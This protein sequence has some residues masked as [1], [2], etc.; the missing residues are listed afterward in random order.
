[1]ALPACGPPTGSPPTGPVAVGNISALA[2]GA[3]LVKSNVVVARDA[4]GVYAMSAVCTHEGC[5][6]NESSDTIA[7]GLSCPCHGSTFDGA[8][9]VTRG[10]ARAPLQHYAVM[11]G[12]DGS[13]TVD[14][15]QPV[16]ASTR[17]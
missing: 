6:L 10:P 16:A 14:G 5:L 2:V 13:L 4:G 9:N 3:M 15:D 11:I 1:M 12:A 8:G 17:A 7:A